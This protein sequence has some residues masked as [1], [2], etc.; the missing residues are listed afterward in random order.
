MNEPRAKH[1]KKFKKRSSRCPNVQRLSWHRNRVRT[2]Q[3]DIMFSLLILGGTGCKHTGLGPR[4]AGE[5]ASGYTYI[6]LDPISVIVGPE[7]LIDK[8]T[9][10]LD[11][12]PDN[13]VRMSMERFDSSG[14]VSYGAGKASIEGQR[15]RIT[16]DFINSDTKTEKLWI[17]RTVEG[18]NP[19]T[20]S[21]TG[22]IYYVPLGEPLSKRRHL[23]KSERI[24]VSANRPTGEL[25]ESYEE[26]FL[27]LYI[28]VGL[29][30]IANI[31]V[32]KGSTDISGFGALGAAAE[33]NRVQGD[34][35]VQTLGVAGE[36]ITAALPIQSDLNQTTVMNAVVAVS[37][38]KAQI[39]NDDVTTSPRLVGL[40][41]PLPGDKRTVNAI[42][43]ALSSR[44]IEW[45]PNCID[46]SQSMNTTSSSANNED[47]SVSDRAVGE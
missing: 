42:I 5:I 12:L 29:R 28:G 32:L 33:A 20:K 22:N 21:G 44:M 38:I 47:D 43:T 15:Y 27:P 11:M 8:D 25:G 36:S 9:K 7:C 45:D 37:S 31:T 18:Y 34:L 24:I 30:V 23:L 2:T 26:F 6:P 3:R 17:A 39:R 35:V 13:A 40:Y 14:S 16:I 46:Q 1:T 41:L 4:T 19:K 10:L